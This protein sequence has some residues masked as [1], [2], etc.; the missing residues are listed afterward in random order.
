[1]V[2]LKFCSS[3]LLYK[4]GQNKKEGN[5]PFFFIFYGIVF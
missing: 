2:E 1:M 5:I 4:K 3:L